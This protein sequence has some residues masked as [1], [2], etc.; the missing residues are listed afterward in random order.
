[1]PVYG[2]LP[3]SRTMYALT[4]APP[5]WTGVNLSVAVS[6]LALF[7]IL[8]G[9]VDGTASP[10]VTESIVTVVATYA[11]SATSSSSACTVITPLA[12]RP[13]SSAS[14]S[15]ITPLEVAT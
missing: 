11:S 4:A 2:V 9:A 5:L 3:P 7:E 1:V 13:M 10:V 12:L 6:L 14:L 15:T 8:C